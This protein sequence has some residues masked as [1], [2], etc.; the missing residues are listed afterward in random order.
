MTARWRK[1]KPTSR[2]RGRLVPVNQDLYFTTWGGGN[3]GTGTLGR[4]T[5]TGGTSR[6][7]TKTIVF[8]RGSNR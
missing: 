4:Y 2:P 8:K 5:P 1:P 3:F 7:I 6:T